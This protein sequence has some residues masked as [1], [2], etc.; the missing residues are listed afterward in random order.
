MQPAVEFE[1]GDGIALAG[2]DQHSIHAAAL[3]VFKRFIVEQVAQLVE[4]GQLIQR[5]VGKCMEPRKAQRQ[6]LEKRP[7]LR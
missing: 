2:D 3:A 5:V 1:C 7:F 4:V 6:G